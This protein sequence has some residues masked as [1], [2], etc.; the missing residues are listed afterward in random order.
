MRLSKD[1]SVCKIL[2][3]LILFCFSAQGASI[4]GVLKNEKKEAISNQK[5]FLDR[6]K[7]SITDQSGNFFFKDIEKGNY[8]LSTNIGDQKIILKSILI[9][10]SF[11]EINLSD[12]FLVKKNYQLKEVQIS[13]TYTTR[14]F[15][16]MPELKE[17]VIYVGKKNEV[18][19]LD[20]IDGN[21][22][23]NNPRQ[24]LGRIPGMNFSET[25]GCGFPSNGFGLR[26]LNPTQSI[27][28]NTRQNGYNITADIFGYNESYYNPALEAV[29]R[30]EIT[31]GASSL[32]FGPQFGGG[33][34]FIMKQPPRNKIFEYS[35]F[36]TI[37]NYG[38]FN[39]FHSIGGSYKKWSYF[40]YAQYKNQVGWRP[41]S[42]SSS[43][44]G[45]AKVDY[46]ATDRFK[47]GLEYSILRNTI[48]MPGGLTDAQFENNNQQ[49]TRARN[50]LNSPW[51]ILATTFD[52]KLSANIS[53]N[54]KTS[55]LYSERNLVWKNEDGGP[56]VSDSI[57]PFT[58]QYVK[59]EVEREKFSS[60]TTEA[61][62]LTNYKALGMNNSLAIGLRYFYGTMKRQGGGPGSIGSDFDLNLYGGDFEYS[63]NYTTIN[64]APFVEHVFRI[65]DQFSITP[66]FRYEYIQSSAIGYVTDSMKIYT[67]DS[68]K[69]NIPLFGIG[70][71]Y[72]IS[73]T[74]NIYGN[75]SQAY[76]PMDYSSLT[77]IG[78]SSKIDPNLTDA[79][80]YNADF[81]WRG[82]FGK[83][84]NFD[85]GGFVLQYNNRI[86][87]LDI[88]DPITEKV[89]TLRTNTG[90]SMS[91]GI[92]TYIELNPV[93][94]LTEKSI[95][96]Y[97]NIFNS[98][99][100]DDA[101]YISG[102][103]KN[104]NLLKGNFVE[105]APQIINR[106]GITYGI[107]GVSATFQISNT[108]KS[109][110]D[111]NNTEKSSDA[112]IGVIPAY[113]VMDFS[114]TYK[115]RN[116]IF[117]GGINN[118]SDSK[119]FTKRTDEYPGPGIIPAL[120]RSFNLGVGAKF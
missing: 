107:K 69:R 109:Y 32:Q 1:T 85:F 49:S 42:T 93:K 95:F 99:A 10:N 51:N 4:I 92:E 115:F 23:Q 11:D 98:F 63:L 48:Q 55:F 15:D 81:G 25:E 26:G 117:K 53:L 71:E 54:I 38:L 16:R 94:M 22:A 43:L 113:K 33:V 17:N 104:G 7:F 84:L 14:H 58:N 89:T 56:E 35:I 65:N 114:V 59:R 62:L 72:K 116:I 100:F 64:L 77:P 83:F 29:E 70:L 111:A 112:I 61:R 108:S 78:V 52:Y 68:R 18:L 19:L 36:Q 9:K 90:N 39:S 86:G 12:V 41:N 80:G 101:R 40:V 66:G 106:F 76:R 60:T 82:T 27:E 21:K 67:N 102:I 96:G 79:S 20:H 57:S 110:S 118:I 119:Y 120:G 103:D 6:D 46:Q 97:V 37:G 88:K 13:E 87:L 91:K 73:L 5:I 44:T 105:Y 3:P 8:E 75:C 30:I 31:R 28:M 34:N 74:T 47:V 24:I 45:F 2:M 50:W